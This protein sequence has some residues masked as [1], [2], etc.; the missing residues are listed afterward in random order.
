MSKLV[1]NKKNNQTEASIPDKRDAWT[2]VNSL[3]SSK[4]LQPIQDT[5]IPIEAVY[6]GSEVL[7]PVV[8][9]PEHHKPKEKKPLK[10]TI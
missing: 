3:H 1:N 10:R 9:S 6:L 2:T 5:K 4:A 7:S 8:G